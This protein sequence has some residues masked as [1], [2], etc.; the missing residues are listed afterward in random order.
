MLSIVI[1]EPPVRAV[2]AVETALPAESE[3]VHENPTVP[4]SS[5]LSTVTAAV[6]WSV[7]P[8]VA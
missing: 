6:W 3:N 2:T 8:T 1:A 4:S 5:A 7:P